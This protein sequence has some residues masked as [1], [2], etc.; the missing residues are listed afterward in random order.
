MEILLVINAKVD[1]YFE[2]DKVEIEVP[3]AM[4]VSESD[5]IDF[6][7]LLINILHLTADRLIEFI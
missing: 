4:W 3:V 5:R 6:A 1:I 7:L 2:D